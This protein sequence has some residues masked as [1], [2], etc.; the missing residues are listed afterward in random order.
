MPFRRLVLLFVI[1][2]IS[3]SHAAPERIAVDSSLPDAPPITADVTGHSSDGL[4]LRL[5]I[6]SLETTTVTLDGK[7]WTSLALEGGT[8]DGLFGQ[9]A[10]PVWTTLIVV[11]DG[12]AI[13]VAG[14]IQKTHAIGD[15]DIAPMPA[16]GEK[17]NIDHAWYDSGQRAEPELVSV[18]EPARMG[19]ITVVPLVI[20]PLSYDAATR[21]AT[22][23][24]QVDVSMTWHGGQTVATDRVSRT[25][26]ELVASAALNW[27][28]VRDEMGDDGGRLGTWVIIHPVGS[29]YETT[30]APLVDW[31]RRQGYNVIE[32]DIND[33]GS[34]TSSIHSYLQTLYN[35]V[36]PPLEFATFVG[37]ANGTIAIPTWRETLSGYYGEGDHPYTLH[38][39]G[40]QLPDI[41]IGRLSCRTLTELDNIV[42]KILNYETDPPRENTD[43]FERGLAVGDPNDSGI[44]TVFCATWLADQLYGIGYDRVYMVLG[45]NFADLM[46]NSLNE[47]RSVFGYRGF[48][49]MSGFTAGHAS[50]LTNGGMLPFAIF[51]TCDTGSFLSNTTCRSEAFLRNRGGGAIGAIGTATPGTDTRH[52]N[53]YYLG[54]FEGLINTP[55]HRQGAALSRGKLELYLHYA[56]T[57]PDVVEIWSTWNTLMGDP[58]TDIWLGVPDEI[59]VTHPTT[60]PANVG[61]L[62]VVVTAGGL[63]VAGAYVTALVDDHI[64]HVGMTNDAG[65]VLLTMGGDLGSSVDLTVSG[66]NL[67]PYQGSVTVSNQ[68]HWVALDTFH[69]DGDGIAVPTE[70]VGIELVM[71]NLGLLTATDVTVEVVSESSWLEVVDANA[72]FGT[73]ASGSVGAALDPVGVTV[74][75]NT[76]DGVSCQLRLL[77]SSG[78]GDWVSQ[79]VLVVQGSDLHQAGTT[80]FTD[81]PDPGVTTDVVIGIQNVGSLAASSSQAVLRSRS[82]W[83]T[84]NDSTGTYDAVPVG[85][86]ST[87]SADPFTV[88]FADDMVRGASVPLTLVL[89]QTDGARRR[90]DLNV[91]VGDRAVTDPTG[92][93]A[94]GYYAFDSGDI[95]YAETH[96]FDWVEIDPS[97]GGPG[98]DTG[99]TDTLYERDDVDTFSLPFTFRFYGI[100][101][102]QVSICS[103]GW[104]AFGDTDYPEWR[105]WSLPAAGSP[106]A[107]IAVF[108]DDLVQQGDDKVYH[109][110]D[111]AEHRYIVEWSRMDNLTNGEQTCQVILY[112]PEYYPTVSLDGIVVC[113]YLDFNNNDIDRGY[114]TLGIQSPDGH[115]GLCYSY[116][117]MLAPGAAAPHDG[118]AITYVPAGRRVPVTCDVSPAFLDVTIPPDDQHVEMLHIVNDGEDGPP[119]VYDIA[120]VDPALG[121][122]GAKDMT[123]CTVTVTETGYEPGVPLEVHLELYNGSPDDEWIKSFLVEL[124][125]GVDLIGGTD[126]V[127]DGGHSIFWQGASGDGADADWLGSGANMINQYETATGSFTIEVDYG[128]GNL[129]LDWLMVG[130][131]YGGEPHD[132]SGSFDLECTGNMINLLSPNGGEV[133]SAG[134]E[135]SIAWE[136][137]PDVVSL[138]V[139]LSRDGGGAWETLGSS[140]PASDGAYVWTVSGAVSDQCL[141]RITSDDNPLVTDTCSAPFTIQGD[142]SWLVVGTPAGEVLAG[143]SVEI[144]LTFDST[145]MAFGDYEQL[146]VITNSAGPDVVVPVT[147][148][149]SATSVIEELPQVNALNQNHPNPFN[150][151]TIIEFALVRTGPVDLAVYDLN[152][153]RVARLVRGEQAAGR[154]RVLWD[155]RGLDGRTLAS[156]T[157]VYRLVADGEVMSRK[158]T[159]LK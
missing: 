15:L 96:T 142:I 78:G 5:D 103:N 71:R 36:D 82:L 101:H 27:P 141:V 110:F 154:H 33:T 108:W 40:D 47:G 117:N 74:A 13:S 128:V 127:G 10:L 51:P 85:G 14:T 58:A 61:S 100:S 119:L 94:Y 17:T 60:V 104:I 75:D 52:N 114:A 151:Q 131:L 121:G 147:M 76:P 66:H 28:Q 89:Y 12:A 23:A 70:M 81:D 83:V 106:H 30:L 95:G 32:A 26:R 69:V 77:V 38:D 92:S 130:D 6:G 153:R 80:F 86:Q 152:G 63:P 21:T 25:T 146:L 68:D 88:T 157:Y 140:V 112:D 43:W 1:A 159:L 149:V 87:N 116:Y 126:L 115:D 7:E 35:T 67:I 148:H 64:Q 55:E 62:P 37:D 2:I 113:Q 124:P 44:T 122:D 155:G 91:I 99:L 20:R 53:C 56:L 73:I 46:Y 120:Q 79:L 24:S 84:I 4:D 118:F 11:P 54:V 134:E 136:T 105:N 137:S 138:A 98:A 150:P 132:I 3:V 93:D 29:S 50:V 45:G 72:S 90:I 107:M 133:W 65:E 158:L 156:G 39:G 111:E 129:S 34:T 8:I 144:T 143:N 102:D 125:P 42:D 31:R 9:P 123:G 18:G 59:V 139:E 16:T 109:W 49:G 57:E 145:G 48:Y 22:I 135:R 41:H 97:R 19:G